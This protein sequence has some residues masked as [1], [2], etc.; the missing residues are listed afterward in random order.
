MFRVTAALRRKAAVDAVVVG[1]GP[2]G[3]AVVGSLLQHLPQR[4]EQLWVDPYFDG[5]RVNAKYRQVPSNTKVDLFLQFAN[6]LTPFK[7]VLD[8]ATEP[9]AASVLRGLAQ[10]KGCEL[11]KAADL[12]LMLTQGLKTHFPQ[13]AQ[14]IGKATDASFDV[15]CV[16]IYFIFFFAYIDSFLVQRSLDCGYEQS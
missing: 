15:V 3:L 11:G 2:A 16:I 12:C 4:H 8:N 7:H 5:G 9:N 6:Q 13:A 1:A 14:H 10:D